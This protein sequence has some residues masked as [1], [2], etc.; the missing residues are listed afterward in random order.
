MTFAA[1]AGE[2]ASLIAATFI[3]LGL[4]FVG[5]ALLARLAHHWGISPIPFYLLAGLAF[6]D[7]GIAG[8]ELSEEFVEFG[9]EIGVLLL[10]FMLGLEYSAAELGVAVRTQAGSGLIDLLANFTPGLLLGLALGWELAGAVLLGGVTYISSSGVI[11][12]VL[13]DLDRLGNRETPV[14]LGILVIEDLVMALYLPLVSVAFLGGDGGATT[15]LVALLAL[16]VTLVLILRFDTSLSRMID[17]GSAEGLLLMVFGSVLFIAGLAQSVQISSAVGAFLVGIALSGEVAERTRALLTP[18]RDLFAAIFF[19]FFS[20]QINPRAIPDVLLLALLLAVV[21]ALTKVGSGWWAAARAG[22]ATRGRVRAGMT[23]IARG[24]FSIVIAG[25]AVT[26][27]VEPQL[28]P[29]AAAYVLI[30]AVA[31]PLATR[32]AD[33]LSLRFLDRVPSS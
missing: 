7:G 26:G 4:G 27:G 23:L 30:L 14:V 22:V 17:T 18:M 19:V 31:G 8:L 6:G 15:I 20:L 24:E 3:E 2:G 1:A 9:A 32:F 5:L 11:A 28:G 21:T 10:L 33:D 12:K 13:S 16:T 25:L 29:L